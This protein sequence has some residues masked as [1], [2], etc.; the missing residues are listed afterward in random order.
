MNVSSPRGFE[1]GVEA[2]FLPRVAPVKRSAGDF[3]QTSP[4]LRVVPPTHARRSKVEEKKSEALKIWISE[5]L[6]LEL[7]KLA[8][9][10]DRK[11]SDYVARVLER[12]VY[13]HRRAP[14]AGQEGPVRGE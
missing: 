12:H 10:D 2:G 11:L 8:D 13:G 7:S 14:D 3:L 5:S 9:V 1:P 4:A 6:L